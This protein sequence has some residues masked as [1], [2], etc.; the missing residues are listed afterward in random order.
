[1]IRRQSERPDLP[2][3]GPFLVLDGQPA[4]AGEAQALQDGLG[5]WR[6]DA[7][8]LPALPEGVPADGVVFLVTDG[9]ALVADLSD[10]RAVEL[11]HSVAWDE[12]GRGGVSPAGY[13]VRDGALETF[14]GA[15]GLARLL[16]NRAH[17]TYATDEVNRQAE[18]IAERIDP[19]LPLLAF[20]SPAG[21]STSF[22]AAHA[23]DY[24]LWVPRVELVSVVDDDNHVTT[25]EWAEFADVYADRLSPAELDGAPL[26]PERWILRPAEPERLAV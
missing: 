23:R 10:E 11:G 12:Y 2:M 3:A 26:A 16:S 8:A 6:V 21:S 17:I 9:R 22:S 25:H 15:D 13:T 20:A 24:H 18:A 7:A 4:P 14:Q 5:L 19:A 1:M